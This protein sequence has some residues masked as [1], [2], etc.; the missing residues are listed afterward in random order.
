MTTG[1]R[2]FQFS[3][4]EVSINPILLV[5]ALNQRS[6]EPHDWEMDRR[7]IRRRGNPTNSCHVAID[8]WSDNLF[9]VTWPSCYTIIGEG[10]GSF[11]AHRGPMTIDNIVQEIV[12]IEKECLG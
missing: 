5:D 12:R 3:C 1:P 2:S 8:G 11:V 10:G 4:P 9:M 6:E 7:T